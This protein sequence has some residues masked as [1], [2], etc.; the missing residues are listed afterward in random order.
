ML[1]DFEPANPFKEFIRL[2]PSCPGLRHAVISVAALHQAFRIASALCNEKKITC[3]S[4]PNEAQISQRDEQVQH[5]H[6]LPAY[7]DALSHKQQTLSFLR[8]EAYVG[9]F[10]KPDG[11]IASMILSI[12][13]EL[14]DSGRDT[15]R[16]H[17]QGLRVVMQRRGLSPALF[18]DGDLA[19][20]LPRMSEY[21][22]TSYAM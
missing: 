15:W 3:P 9:C 7:Y 14:M 12:W 17:L 22:D 8:S 4:N 21:F 13:F 1:Y 19:S 18:R 6:Q 10:S 2:I 20:E 11:V 5:L 16:Y